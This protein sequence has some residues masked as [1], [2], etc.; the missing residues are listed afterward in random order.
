M[1]SITHGLG[2]ILAVLGSHLMMK[3]VTSM[4]HLGFRHVMS[5]R[6]YSLSLIVLYMSSTL[7]HSF[8]SMQ[9]TK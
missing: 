2:V 3:R 1:N 6:V 9:N 7:Y 5:C 8:F 4:E